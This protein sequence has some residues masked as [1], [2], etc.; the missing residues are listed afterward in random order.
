MAALTTRSPRLF[1]K[2]AELV[3]RKKELVYRKK[4]DAPSEKPMQG[5]LDKENGKLFKELLKSP[6]GLTGGAVTLRVRGHF[7]GKNWYNSC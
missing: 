4:T 5:R 7:S 2:R 6:E 1:E 3:Y